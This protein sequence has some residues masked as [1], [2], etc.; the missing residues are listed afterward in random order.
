MLPV[1]VATVAA[2]L[3]ASAVSGRIVQTST[4]EGRDSRTITFSA[5]QAASGRASGDILLTGQVAAW[6][7]SDDEGATNTLKMRQLA[8]K[9]DVDCLA[10]AR[11]RAALSGI[12][13]A[14]DIP[15]EVG[16]T[17]MLVIEKASAANRFMWALYPRPTTN[18]IASD[19]EREKDEGIGLSWI[20][21]DAERPDDVGIP[22]T[23]A[24]GTDC[25]SVPL[26]TH[27]LSEIKSGDSEFHF[28]SK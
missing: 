16:R 21:T 6:S 5:R 3:S 23:K 15:G 17:A 25:R 10:V 27:T 26:S 24:K 11:N 1:L 28:D 7:S 22:S 12:I 4:E 9:V 8:V 18:G 13:R 2:A 19:A 14:S 20:A